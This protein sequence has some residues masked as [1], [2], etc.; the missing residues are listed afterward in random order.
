[1]SSTLMPSPRFLRLPDVE[2][3]VGLK[4]S[5]IYVRIKAGAF[6]A[7]VKLGAASRWLESDLDGWMQSVVE[8]QKGTVA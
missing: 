2:A 3:K 8:Q 7:P 4:K 6:P 5:V 1:M